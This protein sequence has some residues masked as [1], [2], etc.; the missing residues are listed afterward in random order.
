MGARGTPHPR[1]P[2]NTVVRVQ[3]GAFRDKL[4]KDIFTGIPDLVVIKG[5]DGLTRYY[6]GSFTDV[7]PAATH[8]VEMLKKG[9]NGAFLVAFKDGKRVSLKRPAPSSPVRRT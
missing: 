2:R 5:D 1:A 4:G 9:F 3:L 7:N 8:K 6:T